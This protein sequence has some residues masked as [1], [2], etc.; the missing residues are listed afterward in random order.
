MNPYQ[1]SWARAS[2]RMT[3]AFAAMLGP[4]VVNITLSVAVIYIAINL[5]IIGVVPWRE[6][7]PADAPSR[8]RAP[9]RGGLCSARDRH[10]EDPRQCVGGGAETSRARRW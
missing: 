9:G 10:R 6:F 3:I 7:V 5:S 4:G 8:A 2:L 1:Q